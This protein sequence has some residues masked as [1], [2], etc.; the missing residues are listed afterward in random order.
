MTAPATPARG[1]TKQAKADAPLQG[2]GPR[3]AFVVQE[4]LLESFIW[5][6]LQEAALDARASVQV[7]S[8]AV[9][10]HQDPQPSLEE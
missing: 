4:A 8:K 3:S 9:S 10:R 6:Y 7:V 5:R 2:R 1:P